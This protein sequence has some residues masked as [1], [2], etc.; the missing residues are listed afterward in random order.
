[1]HEP[2]NPQAHI[3]PL[4]TYQLI[5]S[6]SF[7]TLPIFRGLRCYNLY[8]FFFYS[9][10]V[11][12]F[13]IFFSLLHVPGTRRDSVTQDFAVWMPRKMGKMPARRSALSPVKQQF[14]YGVIVMSGWVTGGFCFCMCKM[15]PFY[16]VLIFS[17]VIWRVF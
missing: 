10:L 4:T 2:G 5:P 6:N 3:L 11:C 17:F 14:R 16:C 12:V 7:P 8:V 9:R 15:W 1:M 13:F